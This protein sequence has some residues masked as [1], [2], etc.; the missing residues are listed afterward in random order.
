MRQIHP[1]FWLVILLGLLAVITTAAATPTTS[2]QSEGETAV[3][4]FAG[5]CF[6]CMEPP[7]DKLEGVISTTSGYTGGTRENPTYKEVSSGRTGHTEAVRIIYD[8]A[9]IDYQT[10]L[11]V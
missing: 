8:P 1:G 9:V 3:A 2:N 6:W 5:G 4:I 10:L 11:D 7:Y